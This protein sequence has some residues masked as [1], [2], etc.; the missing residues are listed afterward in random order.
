[1]GK[2]LSESQRKIFDELR[3]FI[4]NCTTY[5]GSVNN[6][7]DFKRINECLNQIVKSDHEVSVLDYTDPEEFTEIINK[8]NS[9]ELYIKYN[10]KGNNQSS[11]TVAGYLRFLKAKKF[12]NNTNTTA[13]TDCN[14]INNE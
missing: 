6:Y 5:K 7:T 9:N 1:M 4:E 3:F 8:L 14:I 2:N 11:N 13:V 12:F 10:D